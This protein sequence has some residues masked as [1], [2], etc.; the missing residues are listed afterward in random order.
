M[1]KNEFNLRNETSFIF[2]KEFKKNTLS[3]IFTYNNAEKN[4]TEILEN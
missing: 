3:I 2:D 1:I 4:L